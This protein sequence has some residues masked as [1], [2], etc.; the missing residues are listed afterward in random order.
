MITIKGK[1]YSIIISVSLHTKILFPTWLTRGINQN[2]SND[3]INITTNSI[4]KAYHK[5]YS[6]DKDKILIS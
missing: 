5:M 6:T 2:F 4:N 3:S 1:I